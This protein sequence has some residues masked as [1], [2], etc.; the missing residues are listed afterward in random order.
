MG[1]EGD[2]WICMKLGVWADQDVVLRHLMWDVLLL[3][4]EVREGVGRG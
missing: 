4:S 3:H 1:F 2:S